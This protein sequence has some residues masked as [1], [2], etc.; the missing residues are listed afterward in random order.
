MVIQL[1]KRK[2]YMYLAKI[3]RKNTG[4]KAIDLR[5]DTTHELVY[6]AVSNAFYVQFFGNT[7]GNL[8]RKIWKHTFN[9]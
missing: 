6:T 3:R 8:M 5:T 2:K 7:F 9:V 4:D 1:K